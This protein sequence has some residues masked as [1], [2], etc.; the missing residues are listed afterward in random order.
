MPVDLSTWSRGPVDT[1]LAVGP[2]GVT[3]FSFRAS[4]AWDDSYEPTPGVMADVVVLSH[5]VFSRLV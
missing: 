1:K 4:S 3:C 5:R 2:V